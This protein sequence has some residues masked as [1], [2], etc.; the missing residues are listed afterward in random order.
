MARSFW[1]GAIHFGLVNIP[2]TM[3]PASEKVDLDFDLLDVR[4]FAPVGYQ[5]VNKATGEQVPKDQIVKAYRVD[6]GDAVVVT[7]EDFARARP[8]GTHALEI[9]GFVKLAEIRPPF[10]DTPY[11]LEPSGKEAHAYALLRDTLERTKRAAI[12]KGVLRTR[13]RLGA[14]FPEGPFLIF[15]TLRYAHEMRRREAPAVLMDAKPPG[16]EE[17]SMAGQLVGAM[18]SR[19]EPAQYRDEYREEMLAY[20][21]KK[22]ESGQ[23]RHVYAPQAPGAPAA[24][25]GEPRDLMQLLKQSLA[26]QEPA[27]PKPVPGRKRRS[28]S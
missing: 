26:S 11:Y 21:R 7:E 23:R 15:N 8:K 28:A 6:E 9:L 19:F 14:I 12:A 4:D 1:S 17:F 3:H 25:E 18:E 24:A 10:F 27:R 16:A 22:A 20:I 13:E 2:V 5:K